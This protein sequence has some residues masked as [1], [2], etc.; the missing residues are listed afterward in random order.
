MRRLFIAAALGALLTTPA[1]AQ[2]G[3]P[4]GVEPG[5]LEAAPGKPAPHQANTQDR[6]FARLVAVGGMAEVDFAKLADEKAQHR[7]V[8]DF[9]RRMV[10]DH[11]KANDQL[12]GL[13]KRSNIPLPS[14]FDPDQKNMRAELDN[15]TGTAFDVAY[16]QGQVVDHQKTAT[17][18]QYEIG[19]GQDG[20]LQRFAVATL[21]TVLAHLEMARGILTEL[22][23]EGVV[24]M[25]EREGKPANGFR[26]PDRPNQPKPPVS[27]RPDAR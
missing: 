8:K 5:T 27:T 24:Q 13:A 19:L 20:D 26:D 25:H 21:P 15:A 23:G 16:M 18:L 2:I 14:D 11:S 1:G 6:L 22:A 9:A 10:Q 7:S 4:A 17:L 3:N 12:K